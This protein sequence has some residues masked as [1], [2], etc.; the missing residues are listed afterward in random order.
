M[1]LL[2]FIHIP[3]TAGTY[4]TTAMAEALGSR[5]IREGHTVPPC[6]LRPWTER[7]GPAHFSSVPQDR[8]TVFTV[9]RNP[10]DLLVSMYSFGFPYWAPR[11]AR[12][13]QHLEW[14]FRS[15]REFVYKLCQWEDYPW[16][17]PAQRKSLFFQL[18]DDS[19]AFLPDH[20]LR[21]ESLES[22][23]SKL[24]EALGI[25]IRPP[26]KPINVS[27][28]DHFSDYYDKEMVDLVTR[29]FGG[30]LE[31]FGYHFGDYCGN[32]SLFCPQDL[33]FDHVTGTYAGISGMFQTHGSATPSGR[34]AD[35]DMHPWGDE[36]LSR[37]TGQALIA[38]LWSRLRRRYGTASPS[39]G[40][41]HG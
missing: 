27:R 26:Q 5:F 6:T 36:I 20:V 16:I 24:S 33:R 13:R 30:D 38:E 28:S 37:Y 40:K 9:V 39:T 7:F 23:L 14:P 2:Y 11:Y 32:D 25:D 1:D 34:L 3:K 35:V 22:G 41:T 29:R 19:G 10:F 8:C 18:F 12:Q 21:Q 4:V 15:F 31:A 17:V